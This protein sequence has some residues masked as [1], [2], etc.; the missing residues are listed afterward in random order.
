MSRSKLPP[1]VFDEAQLRAFLGHV[2]DPETGCAELRIF[3]ADYFMSTNFVVAGQRYS[4]TFGGWFNRVDDLVADASRVRGVSAYITVNP[5][6]FDLLGRA[7]NRVVTL[8][9]GQGTNDEAIVCLR[10]LYIDLDVKR[11]PDIPST[12]A[13]LRSALDLR[14]RILATHPEIA[15]VS[16]WGCSGNGGWILVRLPDYP[17]NEENINLIGRTLDNLAERFGKEGRDSAFVDSKTRNPS[18]V[19]CLPGTQKA[20]GE[21]L[22]DRPWRPVTIEGMPT[23]DGFLDLSCWLKSHNI[24]G[25]SNKSSTT[26]LLNGHVSMA[27][28]QISN[29]I[30]HPSGDRAQTAYAIAALRNEATAVAQAAVGSRNDQLNLSAFALGQIVAAGWLTRSEVEQSLWVAA[31]MAGLDD[32]EIGATIASG[33]ER[34]S[35]DPRNPHKIGRNSRK[36]N[37]IENETETTHDDGQGDS[38]TTPIGGTSV[39]LGGLIPTFEFTDVGNAKRLCLL[40]GKEIRHCAP[41]GQWLVFD[42]RRWARDDRLDVEAFAKDVPGQILREVPPGAND[43]TLAPLRRWNQASQSR[44]RLTAAIMLAR[45]EA[46]IPVIPANLDRNRWLLNVQNGTIN[47]RTGEFYGHRPS[48]L[49]TKIAPVEYDPDARSLLWD[50]FLMEIMGDDARLVDYLHRAAGYAISG[51]IREHVFFFLY[52]TGRNGKTTWLN[53]IQTILGDYATEIDSDILISQAMGAAQHPT[54]LTELEGRRFIVANEVEDGKRLAEAL[55]KK[56]TGG[57]PIQ[58]R[59]MHKD[60]YT[61]LPSHHIFLA[62]NH[63]PEIRGADPGIWRRVKL[64]PFTVSFDPEIQGGRKPDLELEEKL[65][66][67]GPGILNWLISGCRAWQEK[68]LAEPPPIRSV[69]TEYRQEMDT[70]GWFLEDRC[71]QDENGREEISELYTHFK[72]WCDRT[73]VFPISI[74]R[75]SSQ[76]GD[77]GFRR[78]KSNSLVFRLGIRLKTW[79][80]ME[81]EKT[82]AS[83][84]NPNETVQVEIPF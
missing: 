7:S 9:R 33:I 81:D 71:Y 56:L 32:R 16:L 43:E 12:E 8:Q 22:P 69:M 29:Q 27:D 64:I 10:W 76:L 54:G 70:L 3:R 11:L 74:R 48:D 49:I 20:K 21:N 60:F 5:A 73:G 50:R 75:F 17:N 15:R 68:S 53:T 42:G 6:S 65:V 72:Q 58:A 52:G 35:T 13:E 45:S 46:G 34:G 38:A 30:S 37:S 77:R 18:R 63:K 59:K 31:R 19:M 39:V 2:L 51:V 79:E 4:R 83:S 1:H 55:V 67:E 57:N 36:T 41:Y 47:L 62:A 40:H 44:D 84:A 82:E 28:S 61:F 24:K 78:F 25:S 26:K 23:E 66:D 14:G 80:E